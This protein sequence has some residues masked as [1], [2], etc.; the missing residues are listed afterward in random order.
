MENLYIARSFGFVYRSHHILENWFLIE[1]LLEISQTEWFAITVNNVIYGSDSLL[2]PVHFKVEFQFGVKPQWKFMNY[3]HLYHDICFEQSVETYNK[4]IPKRIIYDFLC[5]FKFVRS[6][7]KHII[8]TPNIWKS[9]PLRITSK[10]PLYPTSFSNC[11]TLDKHQMRAFPKTRI[12]LKIWGFSSLP[13]HL[14]K[15]EFVRIHVRPW[16]QVIDKSAQFSWRRCY[17]MNARIS[18]LESN[19][20]EANRQHLLNN[21]R[22]HS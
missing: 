10:Q 7:G 15:V 12:R 17:F 11:R 2:K 9:C 8:N 3:I 16:L 4:I 14:H 18:K 19:C 5:R 1:I 20:D 21:G 6:K 22:Y 13:Y